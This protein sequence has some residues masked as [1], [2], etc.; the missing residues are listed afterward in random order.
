MGQVGG[1]CEPPGL[2]IRGAQGIGKVKGQTKSGGGDGTRRSRR[3][4]RA[5]AFDNKHGRDFKPELFQSRAALACNL[6]SFV[7]NCV[8]GQSLQGLP[9]LSALYKNGV[10]ASC[11]GNLAD[12]PA[13]FYAPRGKFP[14]KSFNRSSRR[15]TSPPEK[16]LRV[17]SAMFDRR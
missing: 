8:E 4:Q 11:F 13:R 16:Q 5:S 2:E 15:E 10:L 17:A 7:N 1:V 9:F 14:T 6:F 12:R 3:G